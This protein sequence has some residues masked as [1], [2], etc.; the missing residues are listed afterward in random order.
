MGLDQDVQNVLVWP[1]SI[2][3]AVLFIRLTTE[4]GKWGN[5]Q[6]KKKERK[7]LIFSFGGYL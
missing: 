4:E 5:C 2:L 3:R 6:K 7:Q 1:D